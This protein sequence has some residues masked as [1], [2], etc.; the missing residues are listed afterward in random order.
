MLLGLGPETTLRPPQR[1]K[2]TGLPLSIPCGQNLGQYTLF[3][4]TTGLL[5]LKGTGRGLSPDLSW[6]ISR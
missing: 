5:E 4:V 6:A 2:A 3:K 1:V